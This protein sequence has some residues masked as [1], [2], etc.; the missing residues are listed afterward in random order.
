[1]RLQIR[2]EASIPN[3]YLVM[4]GDTLFLKL[5]ALKL[6]E[7]V[8]RATKSFLEKMKNVNPSLI[9]LIE[10]GWTFDPWEGGYLIRDLFNETSVME[11]SPFRTTENANFRG[12]LTPPLN[13]LPEDPIKVL[14]TYRDNRV[15]N[16][17][18]LLYGH[19]SYLNIKCLYY[20]TSGVGIRIGENIVNFRSL[21]GKY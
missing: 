15:Q 17:Y 21:R 11:P 4:E 13:T 5:H 2:R 3:N 9:D 19:K 12:T 14:Y 6:H 1:M 20:F 7:A 16:I 18:R 8:E 10:S